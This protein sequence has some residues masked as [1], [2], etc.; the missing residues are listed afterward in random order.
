MRVNTA[1][2]HTVAVAVTDGVSVFELSVPCEVFGIDRSDLG[3]P[4]YRF[5]LCAPEAGEV[6]TTAGFTI[7]TRHGFDALARADTIIVPP[8]G[9]RVRPA[10]RR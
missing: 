10:G 4:W 1:K 5:I 3:V 9:E 8:L 7:T 6:T 2:R